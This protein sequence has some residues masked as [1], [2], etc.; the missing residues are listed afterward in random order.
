VSPPLTHSSLEEQFAPAVPPQQI[1]FEAIPQLQASVHP[2]WSESS[3]E[4]YPNAAAR[5]LQV[6]VDVP[7]VTR[8]VHHVHQPS[9]TNV[10][11]PVNFYAP[12]TINVNGTP[13]E[14]KNGLLKRTIGQR[15]RQKVGNLVAST[16]Y[17]DGNGKRRPVFARVD[18][19]LEAMT[20][21]TDADRVPLDMEDN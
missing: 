9:V 7:Q 1:A 14:K 13:V 5:Q 8:D 12:V 4:Q 17:V 20:S 21:R 19:S 16:G 15:I 18:D 3:N 2:P 6:P 10:S 11:A